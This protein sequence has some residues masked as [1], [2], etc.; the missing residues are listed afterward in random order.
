MH[1]RANGDDFVAEALRFIGV[2]Y[3]WGGRSARGLD[4]SA[5]VQLALLGTGRPCPRDSDMQAALVGDELA[6]DA[7]LR[8]GDL[9]FW[10]GHV[11]ILTE[12]GT[13]LHANGH[14][15]AV[16]LEPFAPA[17]ARIA[18]AGGGPV[19]ALRRIAEA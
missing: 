1:L 9:V 5:L 8:R 2:P 6:P 15:M 13:L 4:C 11:G 18:A 17:A 3:L 14:H 7:E 12:P 16:A 19:T 10:H